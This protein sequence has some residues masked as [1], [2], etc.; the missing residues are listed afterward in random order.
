MAKIS[1]KPSSQ[2]EK[3]GKARKKKSVYVRNASSVSGCRGGKVSGSRLI[4]GPTAL[5]SIT[6]TYIAFLNDS[7]SSFYDRGS[8]LTRQHMKQARIL[9]SMLALN[10]QGGKFACFALPS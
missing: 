9:Y 4:W 8:S 6:H 7:N 1:L 3:E 5:S 10:K 2:C